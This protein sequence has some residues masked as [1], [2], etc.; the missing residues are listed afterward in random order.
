MKREVIKTI[1]R[2]V[3]LE[4]DDDDAITGEHLGEPAV[5]YSRAQLAEYLDAVDAD[6]ARLNA[7]AD[8]DAP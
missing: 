4:R 6:I 7:D 3:I 2:V 8:A 1:V 5:L